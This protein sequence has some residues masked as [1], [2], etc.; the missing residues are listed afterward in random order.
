ML[1]TGRDAVARTIEIR[2]I[3]AAGPLSN[4]CK[5]GAAR[6]GFPEVLELGVE[7]GGPV[8]V[9]VAVDHYRKA[10]ALEAT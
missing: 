4:G 6:A 8:V 7:H 10:S 2:C 1:S 5:F 3:E 9:R